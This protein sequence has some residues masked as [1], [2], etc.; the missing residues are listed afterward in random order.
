[1]TALGIKLVKHWVTRP[2]KLQDRTG[3][4]AQI[5]KLSAWNFVKQLWFFFHSGLFKPWRLSTPGSCF[6]WAKLMM[7]TWIARGI[8]S[9]VSD[10]PQADSGISADLWEK[11]QVAKQWDDRRS[12]Q[13]PLGCAF[14][15]AVRL[16]KK[17]FFFF[18]IIPFLYFWVLREKLAL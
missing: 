9:D 12:C 6:F 10:Y 11:Q 7:T 8:R 17:L 2:Y 13:T 18:W 4:P 1:M 16:R 15:V 14:C 5:W 3:S